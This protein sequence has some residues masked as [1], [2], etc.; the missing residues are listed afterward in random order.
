[1]KW[2]INFLKTR[3]IL[4]IILVCLIGSIILV[5][6]N[7][8]YFETSQIKYRNDIRKSDIHNTAEGIKKFISE[9]NNCPR[10]SNPVP[11]AFLPEL[12]FDGSNNPKGGVSISTLE[13]VSNFIEEN[14]KDPSGSP[15]LVGTFDNKIYIYTNSFEVYKSSNQ[16]YFESIETSL[17]NQIAN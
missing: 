7:F 11:E 14:K 6:V 4:I 15:Y 2:F 9:K 8:S 1:M 13:D 5:I 3:T 10:T 12:I 16:T 17:C